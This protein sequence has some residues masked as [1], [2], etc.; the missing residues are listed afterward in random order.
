VDRVI[1]DAYC[2]SNI[3]LDKDAPKYFP[4]LITTAAFGAVGCVLTLLLGGW[5][6]MDNKRRNMKQ[7]KA[8]RAK[9]I[10]TELLAEGPSSPDYRWYL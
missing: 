1:D 10:P 6:I 4:A 8:V 5:M 9:E 7:G 2:R 3:F